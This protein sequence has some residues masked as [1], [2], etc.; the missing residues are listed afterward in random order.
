MNF[1]TR[2]ISVLMYYAPDW[3]F[4]YYIHDIIMITI[5]VDYRL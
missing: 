1:F 2:Y 4:G 3:I 5:T